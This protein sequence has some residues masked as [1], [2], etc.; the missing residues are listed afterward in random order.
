MRFRATLEQ[1]GK[2][3]TGIEVP[4]DVVEKLGGARRPPV[5]V[6]INGH[7]YRST[8]AVMG[9]RNHLGVSAENRTAAGVSAGDLIDVDL[10]TEK[11]E[12]EEGVEAERRHGLSAVDGCR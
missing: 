4:E 10:D 11:R 8:V 7:T 9:G 12:V 2:T 1:L 5:R 6:T 3:A